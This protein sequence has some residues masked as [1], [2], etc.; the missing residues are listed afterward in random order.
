M[1]SLVCFMLRAS[2][3]GRAARRPH[4]SFS[5]PGWMFEME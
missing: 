1:A 2:T 4:Q 5:L 3:A